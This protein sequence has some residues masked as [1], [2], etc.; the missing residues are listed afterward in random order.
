[1]PQQHTNTLTL[2]K[3]KQCEEEGQLDIEVHSGIPGM[4]KKKSIIRNERYNVCRIIAV[5]LLLLLFTDII[6]LVI[7]LGVPHYCF[8]SIYTVT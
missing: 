7:V 2:E 4:G 5:F 6:L 8:Y 3:K 1:M